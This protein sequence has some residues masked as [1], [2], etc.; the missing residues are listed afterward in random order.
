LLLIAALAV[1]VGCGGSSQRV[2]QRGPASSASRS[3]E[4]AAAGAQLI[5]EADPICARLNAAI[6]ARESS[7]PTVNKAQLL[8][9][10][11]QI[12]PGTAALERE[13]DGQ[14]AR[15]TPPPSLAAKWSMLL[16]YRKALASELNELVRA[17]K[18]GDAA[19]I[20]R[21]TR[22]K[23]QMH[24]RLRALALQSGFKDCAEVGPA[25]PPPPGRSPT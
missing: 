18:H 11:V 13:A 9:E 10:I 19:A 24:G 14:L 20:D 6:L 17:A 2:K 8:R 5:A 23:K 4:T 16:S 1:L 15:L 22:S 7:L 3:S 12:V 25:S 21:L